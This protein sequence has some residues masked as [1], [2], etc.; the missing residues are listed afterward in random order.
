MAF[1][2][3]FRKIPWYLILVFFFLILGIGITGYFY[4][5]HQKG[6]IKKAKEN[7]LSAI[8]DLKVNQIITWYRERMGDA[9]LIS[10]IPFIASRVQQLFEKPTDSKLRQQVFT[11][12]RSLQKNYQYESVILLDAEGTVQLS[13]PYGKQDIES[14]EKKLAAK[15][16]RTKRAILSDFY[17][18]TTS[19][20]GIRLSLL[21]PI[22]VPKG[23]DAL[24]PKA[25]LLRI[26]PRQS[27]YIF[28]QSWPAP[29]RTAEILLVR[30]EGKDIVY[31]NELRHR[32][33]TTLSLR[34]PITEK[35]LPAAMAAR[36]QKGIVEGFDYR[37]V[38]VLAA[39]RTIP[40][41][42]WFLVAKVDQDEVYAPIRERASLMM[43][44]AIVLIVA[45]GAIIGLFWR[46]QR[47]QFYRKQYQAE[48]ERLALV[49]HYNYLA[50]YA[51]DIIIMVDSKGG[52]VDANDRAISCYGYTRDEFFQLNIKH[53]H[54]PETRVL[55]DKQLKKIEESNGL[56][57]ETVHQRKD[58]TT[59]PVEISSRV[60]AVEGKNFYQG[61]IRDIT[62]RKKADEKIQRQ[63]A[64]LGAINKV[65]RETLTCET[66]EEVAN[67]CL[68]VTEELT[69]SKFGFIGDI[70]KSGR[71]DTI[72]LSDPGWD[73]CKIPKSSA[74]VMIRDM[75]IRGIWSRVLKDGRS[76]I[77]N[78]PLSHSDRVGT[79]AGHPSITCFLGVPLQ[80][81]GQ[82]IGMIALANKESGYDLAD[83]EA[84]EA[85]SV[86][87]MEALSRK[88]AK[89]SLQ[90][91]ERRFQA[92]AE[93]TSDVIV[94]VD[95]E[96]KI[97]LWNKAAKEIFGYSEKEILGKPIQIL[98]PECF[99]ETDEK[100]MV[101]FLKTGASSSIGK[102]LELLFL[103]KD[104][105]EFPGE[106][107]RFG[108][109]IGDDTFIGAI[110]RDITERKRA[111]E[112]KARLEIQFSQSQKMEAVGHLVGGIAHDFNNILT[113]II[114]YASLLQ[115]KIKKDD[116]LM[117]QVEQILTSS[118]RATSLTQSLLAFGRKQIINPKPVKI[119]EIVKKVEKILSRIIG[120]DIKLSTILTDEDTVVM[121]DSGQIEQILMNLATNSRDAIS[122]GGR[123]TIETELVEIDEEYVR[124]HGYGKP[125]KYVLIAFT[126]TGVGMDEK[127][128]AMVFEPF[129]T[130]KEVGKG[131]GLGLSM[132]Y[133]IVKQHD[134]YIN[135]YSEPYKGTI[136]K[137]YLP[138]IKAKAEIELTSLT[139]SQP[140][141]GTE[142]ILVAEDDPDVR[143]LTRDILER[144][145]YKIVEAVNGKDAIKAFKKHREEIQLLLL[146]VVMPKKNGKEVYNAIKKI[147]PDMKALFISGY[148]ANV[149]HK[150]GFLDEGLDFILKPASPNELLKKVRVV[151]DR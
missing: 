121:A 150:R 98:L 145:G 149:I 141:G 28:I 60:I 46:Q 70:N 124:R 22:L 21:A 29:T 84:V 107:S 93:S 86:A 111:E 110:I 30:R 36:G 125:G 82:T 105:S 27:L 8:A 135:C 97:N 69:G 67:T 68:T 53:L 147:K 117:T 109:K 74:V 31:L 58:G 26:D 133:G 35:Q 77:V 99:R 134:G 54:S 5:L 104:G 91:S 139:A 25:L 17:R 51:N 120:E 116:P 47:I 96:G 32:K 48:L 144:F 24:P 102:I 115:M 6:N 38:P 76:L 59:F 50:K 119:N 83:L 16:M 71:F 128:R 61:I 81:A 55:L 131:S 114:G 37:G 89:V 123:L 20:R 132:V 143:K 118:Q 64:V 65:F 15:A 151:L 72:A 79:P 88:R 41:S 148:T 7:E 108:W 92:I 130:T 138:L 4:Y 63:G 12:M 85:L 136:F 95:A 10:K 101:E 23:R 87:L 146:D 112:E 39:I 80:H 19:A 122:A 40:N 106:V 9:T 129:F 49:Q 44:L 62:E 34:L 52:I 14:Y 3:K 73:A 75:E 45:A 140:E 56:I 18:S 127:T 13:V 33:H 94:A 78:N 142:T 11:W 66:D 90:R 43:T 57:Y 2:P 137:I 42:P 113:T 103:K 1:Q 126:D 100:G